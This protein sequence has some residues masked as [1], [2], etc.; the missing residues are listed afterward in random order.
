MNHRQYLCLLAVLQ[1]VR[2]TESTDIVYIDAHVCVNNDWYWH[3]TRGDMAGRGV[4]G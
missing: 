3:R 4:R 2:Y 1:C